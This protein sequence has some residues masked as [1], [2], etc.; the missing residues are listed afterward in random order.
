MQSAHSLLLAFVLLAALPAQQQPDQAP[1]VVTQEKQNEL[2]A[3]GFK[4][5]REGRYDVAADAFLQLANSA[6]NRIDWVVAA[7]R[8]LGRSGRF[9]EAI[10]LLDDGRKRFAGD[11]D[12]AA[13]LARTLLLQ[14]DSIRDMM[15]PEI[16]WA[17][18]AGISEEVLRIDPNHQDCRLLLAQARYLLG[19]WDEAVRQAEEAVQR[20]PNLP[21][22][23]VLLGRIA[24]D[25]FR[26]L[27]KKFEEAKPTGGEASDFI[28]KIHKQ[29][30]AAKLAFQAAAKLDTSRAHPH[31][32]LSNLASIDG[33]PDEAKQH[34]IDAL[35]IDPDI[36]VNHA[37][38]TAGMD[39]QAR[40][41]LY[42]KLR[43]QFVASTKLPIVPR[44][45]KTAT[46]Y[47]LE[48][49]ALIDGLQFKAARES[50]R[51]ALTA[52]P[53]AKNANY[54]CFLAA[55]HL[56]DFDDAEQHAADYARAGAPAFADVL[57]ALSST[58]RAQIAAMIQFLGDRA[59]KMERIA[60]S[61]DLNHVTACLLDSADAW[62]NHAFLCR[63][64]SEFES[65]YS[66]YQHAIEKEPTSAQLWNDAAVVLHY[67]LATPANLIKARSM[68]EKSIGLAIKTLADK[69]ISNQLREYAEEAKRNAQA[70]IAE[71]DKQ[72]DATKKID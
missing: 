49:R 52:N 22:A 44:S 8:C 43:A 39:W 12:I 68:Y 66:S 26:R 13:M 6:P 40:L 7:G 59:F 47:F 10:D 71:L 27:L 54:Y 67:H 50:F 72:S 11:I 20:H 60:N 19:N 58:E 37:Q 35:G 55:Y 29:R 25:R 17:D 21:G 16:M 15:N 31:V 61:R 45:T 30:V 63:E 62:N 57:R 64:T 5:E 3:T 18:A 46:L 34:L 42:Q 33:K 14:T 41:D 51:L 4:A 70:N 48:G 56:T 24:T 28:A 23:H 65:A 53:A 1:A 69:S 2:R 9:G 36:A 32:A 38:L